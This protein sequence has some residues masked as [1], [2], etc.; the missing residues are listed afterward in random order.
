MT[1]AV[2]IFSNSFGSSN[3]TVIQDPTSLHKR[4]VGTGGEG[5]SFASNIWKIHSIE[6]D[7]VSVFL[8]LFAPQFFISSNGTVLI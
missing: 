1:L 4:A 6:G 5:G 8:S 2:P 7:R 3:H